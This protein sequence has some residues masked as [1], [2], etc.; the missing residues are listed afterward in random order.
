MS[1]HNTEQELM[2]LVKM[3]NQIAQNICIGGS[4]E[5]TI[6][7]VRDH[8][9]RFWARPMKEK[10]CSA[11]ESVEEELSPVAVEAFRIIKTEL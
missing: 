10:I 3:A 9:T 6:N 7:Q 11:L 4:N 5:E 2:H 1:S 8:I